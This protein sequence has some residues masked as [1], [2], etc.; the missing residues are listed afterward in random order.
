MSE[1]NVAAFLESAACASRG[2]WEGVTKYTH[3]DVVFIPQRAPVRGGWNGHDGLREFGEDNRETFDLFQVSYPDVRDLGDKVLALGTVRIR[4]KGSGAEVEVPS[5]IVTEW[6][7]GK[8][9]RF[10]DFGDVKKALAAV[11]LES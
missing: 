3:P 6:R 10:E 1:E 5:A 8:M 7:D 4:G 2:D 11:G 9:T